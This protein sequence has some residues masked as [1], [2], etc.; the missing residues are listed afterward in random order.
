MPELKV[1]QLAT[2]SVED[3][4]E[5]ARTVSKLNEAHESG[6]MAGLLFCWFDPTGRMN[7]SIGQNVGSQQLAWGISMLQA[8]LVRRN[9]QQLD[10]YDELPPPPAA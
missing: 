4:Q 1:A 7:F 6:K 3:A 2:R 9:L 5:T 8:A 10:D